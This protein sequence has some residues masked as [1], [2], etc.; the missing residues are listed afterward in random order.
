MFKVLL[1]TSFFVFLAQLVSFFSIPYIGSLSG[2]DQFGIYSQLI[3]ISAVLAVFASL[4]GE[5]LYYS[6]DDADV[7]SVSV[8][9]FLMVLI[10]AVFAATYAIV[11]QNYILSLAMWLSVVST[12]IFDY[13]L[14]FNIS[15]GRFSE[16]NIHRL[17]RAFAFPL[18]VLIFS[19][20]Y[21]VNA[22]LILVSFS[23]SSLS[24][25]LFVQFSNSNIQL[26]LVRLA[27]IFENVKLN[28][29]AMVPAH[30]LKQYSLASIFIIS[31]FVGGDAQQMGVYAMLFKFVIAP[32]SIIATAIGEVYR[33]KLM[34]SPATAWDFYKKI[35]MLVIPTASVAAAFL[36]MYGAQLFVLI[37][38]EGW[39]GAEIYL[40]Y[41]LPLFISSMCFPPITY[42]YLVLGLQRKDLIWQFAN[43]IVVTLAVLVGFQF[44]LY[45]AVGAYAL[46]YSV[47][48][49]LSFLFC[50][51]I[52]RMRQAQ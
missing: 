33:K 4:K 30:F 12:I 3:G 52:L 45:T 44:D 26:A 37:M 48:L 50:V 22:P 28:A 47:M 14:Q 42:T 29:C 36:H 34:D 18:F 13:R 6:V 41:L 24:P 20:F 8:L 7:R 49:F 46:T 39:T 19:N 16:N 17:V 5:Y 10:T 38:G 15:Q 31:S 1:S 32:A 9:C 51:R 11:S 23:L 2:A 40:P 43:S 21:T 35:I 27:K 25:L